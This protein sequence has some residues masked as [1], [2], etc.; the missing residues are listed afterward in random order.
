MSVPRA[1]AARLEISAISSE[2]WTALWMPGMAFQWV[3]LPI[4]KC[5]QV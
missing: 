3:Q 4:V 1:V 5:S 2:S